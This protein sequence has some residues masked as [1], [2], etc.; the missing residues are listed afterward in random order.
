MAYV[1]RKG[2]RGWAVFLDGV[3]TGRVFRVPF[4]GPITSY[5]AK[6]SKGRL[7]TGFATREEAADIVEATFVTRAAHQ[8]RYGYDA[9]YVEEMAIRL[10]PPEE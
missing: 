1:L 3:L 7:V 10:A 2:Y 6:P 4:S 5:S 9:T 8:A